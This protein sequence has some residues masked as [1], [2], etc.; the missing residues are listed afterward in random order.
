MELQKVKKQNRQPA[1]IDM[2]FGRVPPQSKDL[3]GAIL[4]AIMVD[5]SAYDVVAELLTPETFYVDANQRI[6]KAIQAL[7]SR[8]MPID[9]LTVVEQLKQSEELDI[10]GGAFYVSRLTNDVMSGAN[11]EAHSRIIIQKYMA[12]RLITLGGELVQ[13]AYDDSTDVFDLIDKFELALSN[14]NNY[15]KSSYDSLDKCLHD[16]EAKVEELRHSDQELTGVSSGFRDINR[17]TCGWQQPDLIILAA[18]PSVGKTAFALNL[19]RGAVMDKS[20]PTGVGFFSLEMSKM[21]LTQRLASME[22]QIPLEYI[23][24]G[25][26]SDDTMQD[27]RKLGIN[28]LQGK[29]VF[30]DDTPAINI[31]QLRS[32]ARKMVKQGVGLI[33]IDYL[34]LMAGI[35]NGRPDNREQEISKISRDLKGLCKELKIPIIALSQLSRATETRQDKTPVLSDLRESGAIE[36]DADVVMFMYRPEYYGKSADENGNNL[37]GETQIKFAKHRSG[38]LD[39]IKLKADLRIQKFHDS[40]VIPAQLGLTG[41]NNQNSVYVQKG[42]KMADGLDD[43]A[44]F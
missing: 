43:E 2:S 19:L 25:K 24:R 29:R 7:V 16:M 23:T 30:I 9:L 13:L 4:G 37:A 40:E 12:R 10:V 20:N 3:E 28:K 33:F 35:Q 39:I 18:R 11:I 42:S 5:K 17:L 34:Q 41:G 15:E 38:A 14:V 22:S 32:K 1:L 27:L 44:P 36:Q 6:Y 8:N 26:L 21:Q 31:Y